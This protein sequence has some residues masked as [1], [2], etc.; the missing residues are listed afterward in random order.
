MQRARTLT[1]LFFQ[2]VRQRWAAL[3]KGAKVALVATAVL[4]TAV[5]VQLAACAFGACGASG[6]C[7]LE[8]S[9][10][11]HGAATDADEP[12]PYSARRTAPAAE[13][14]TPPCHR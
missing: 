14:E 4:V 3:G 1:G 11:C 12:C 9:P 10:P 2:L 7:G 8:S 13:A 6:P 5:G